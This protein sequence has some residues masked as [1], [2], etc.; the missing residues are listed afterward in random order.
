MSLPIELP[1]ADAVR[2]RAD[3][4]AFVQKLM[5]AIYRDQ[6]ALEKHVAKGGF[7]DSS[8]NHSMIDGLDGLAAWL[9]DYFKPGLEDRIEEPADPET[10]RWVATCLIVAAVY[11]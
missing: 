6:R 11:E 5:N 3:L 4:V 1:D 2:S 9:D 10:W 8:L 7:P